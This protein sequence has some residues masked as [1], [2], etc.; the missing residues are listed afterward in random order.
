[1][2]S[3]KIT[4]VVLLVGAGLAVMAG[5]LARWAWQAWQSSPA[6]QFAEARRRWEARPFRRYRLAFDDG[7]TRGGYAQCHHA[8][9][10]VDDKIV[11]DFGTTCLSSHV[12][13]ALSVDGLFQK[14]ERYFD[15]RVC[16]ATGCYCEGVYVVKATYDPTWGYPQ[17]ITTMFQR[18]WVDDFLH[19]KLW[20]QDCLRVD[21]VVEKITVTMLIPLP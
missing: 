20:V 18:D 15:G 4:L 3:T 13:Q 2:R 10:V 19:R 6:Y 14:F 8:V 16:S 21:P 17:T 5:L 9:E 1:M 11:R 7:F 12:T